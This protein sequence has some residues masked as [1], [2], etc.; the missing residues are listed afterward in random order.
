[1]RAEILSVGTEILLGDIVNT[2]AQFLAR[3]LAEL[4]FSVYYQTVVG[5]N[6]ARLT[7]V[8]EQAKQRSEVLLLTGGLGPTDDDLTKQTVA[9]VFGDTLVLDETELDSIRCFFAKRGM[10]MGENNAKQ[11][12]MP[13]NGKKLPNP[14]GTAPGAMFQQNGKTAFLMPGPPNEM[15]PMF[16]NEIRP[17]L[18]QMQDATIHSITLRVF[19]VGESD[20]ENR[21]HP[22]LEGENPTA[23]LYA[24]TGEVHIRVT[25][26]AKTGQE[27]E[28]MCE[29]LAAQVQAELG[30]LVYSTNGDNLETTVVQTLTRQGQTLATA[31]SCTGGLVSKRITDVPGASAVF[32]FG[33]CTYSNEMK[34]KL[35]GVKAQTLAAH[36]AVSSQTAAEMAFGIAAFAGADY[37]VGITG[38]A[39]PD[40]GTPTHPVGLVYVGACHNGRVAIKKLQVGGRGRQLVRVHAAQHALDMVRRMALGMEIPGAQLFEE[41]TPANFS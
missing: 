35:L 29:G 18:L 5:D 24:K 8:V 28:K 33:A 11:A 26:C 37:G 19:G 23:A 39:G 20:L 10:P 41:G 6:P 2:N 3:Q 34:Q 31:E 12:M 7:E 36:G 13:Q 22:L 9:K 16:L 40:G 15:K 38:I 32:T 25:A 1:M 30:N 27:A 21:L 14:N 17:Y 4:G